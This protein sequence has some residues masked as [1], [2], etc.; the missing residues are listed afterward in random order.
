ME[1]LSVSQELA[2]SPIAFQGAR[3]LWKMGVL[4]AIEDA[5]Q[6]GATITYLSDQTGLSDY[7]IGVLVDMGK[8]T[9]TL[10]EV[11]HHFHM[12]KLGFFIL[13]DEMTQT[14][15]DFVHDSC[16][17][18]AF[19]LE[20]ALKTGR[21][22][23]LKVF[24]NAPTLYEAL[25]TL[26]EP[27]RS[28]W[29]A[30]DHYYSDRSF[31]LALEHVFKDKPRS[32]VDIGGNTGNWALTCLQHCPDVHLTLVDLPGQLDMARSTIEEA[33]FTNR[34]TFH[35]AD[36]L[37]PRSQL[38]QGA[39]IVW[40][41]QFLDCFGPPEIVSILSRA[42]SSLKPDARI[43]IMELFVDRQTDEASAFSLNATSLYFSFLANG[44]SRMYRY[45][46]FAKLIQEAGL[47][48]R[49]EVN[50]ISNWHTLLECQPV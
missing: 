8:S 45:A 3:C 32:I 14:N 16:Y 9:R 35:E 50:H 42:Q 23:G 34:V 46:D 7:A 33:G 20:E 27:A 24:S 19:H 18:A 44:N 12:T 41:S 22:E 25:S 43:F 30:F 28:S 6:P 29:L 21:P 49:N 39:D 5:G 31:P 1:A 17:Q 10:D 2:F 26:P 11:D 40:M 37:D 13:H 48:V 38:P 47:K 36:L 15:I 4:K